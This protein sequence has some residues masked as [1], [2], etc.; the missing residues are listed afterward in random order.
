[1]SDKRTLRVFCPTHEAAFETEENAK[2]LCEITGHAL[3]VGFPDTEFWE[4]CCNCETF[5]PSRLDKG[6]KARKT[7]YGCGGD[8]TK[9]F[10]C[11][12]CQILGFECTTQTRGKK[13][14]VNLT[15][16]ID[17]D[18][19]GCSV[20]PQ[21]GCAVVHQCQEID[22]EVFTPRSTCPFCLEKTANAIAPDNSAPTD[23]FLF[24]SQCRAKNP[25]TANF[26]G[27]CNYQLKKD[28]EIAKRGDDIN[29]TQ[30]LGSLCPNCS[31]P[32]PPDS[33]FCGE[34]GQ[35]VKKVIPPPP[36]PPSHHSTKT[37]NL[38]ADTVSFDSTTSS[39]T[40]S[41]SNN[42]MR[43]ISL[44]VGGVFLLIIILAVVSSISK[45]SN[46]SNTS[47]AYSNVVSNSRPSNNR[48]DSSSSVY[49]G[50]VSKTPNNSSSDSRIGRTGTLNMDSN[51][52]ELPSK[53][54]AWMGTHY[55]SARV[56]V[57]DV[58]T[59]PNSLGGTTD[60]F[61]IEVTSYGNS[62]DPNKY[63]QSGK[64]EGSGDFGWVNSYPEVYEGSRRVRRTLVNFD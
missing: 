58:A 3:S 47:N 2:I 62:M 31:T 9:R 33:G 19:P 45:S 14:S 59:V 11:A 8:I 32:I 40:A 28:A 51:L 55:R 16:G 41:I 42:T 26:C 53:D 52:R 54:S 63:G 50:T 7:C 34:C 12:D 18:C 6:E 5:T 57:L 38:A 4:F 35:A 13:Y 27:K 39:A 49:Q 60:W 29:K 48:S 44:G 25:L 23:R 46:V 43:N 64:D 61:K 36:P 1:M 20:I 24:C 10:L 21:T 17:S 22:A 30:F 37:G 56:K 15:N